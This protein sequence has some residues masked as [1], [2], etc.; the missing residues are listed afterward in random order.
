MASTQSLERKTKKVGEIGEIFKNSGV[1]LID[2]RGLTVSEMEDLRNRIKSCNAEI[3]I[4]KNR[5]AIKYFEKEK[6]E[7]GREIFNGPT[8]V[9]YSDDNYVEVAKI[10]CDFEK[11]ND[12]IKIKSGFIEDNFVDKNQINYVAKLPNK[13]Q[14]LSQFAFAIAT[15]VKKMAMALSSPLRNMLILLI[16]LK[17]KKEKEDNNG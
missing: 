8:A 3:K 2:Y 4:I 15:P 16:N 11:E 5:L 13:D 9:A 14:L 17:D 1:Y 12:K 7:Y 10:I 6:K